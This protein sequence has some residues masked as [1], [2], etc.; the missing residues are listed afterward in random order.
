MRIHILQHVS[1][2]SPGLITDWAKEKK[3]SVNF[4]RF[5]EDER[6]PLRDNFDLLV[7]MGGPMNIYEKDKYPWLVREKA[8]LQTCFAAKKKI[9]GI[10]LG[11]QLL[12]DALGATVF[13]NKEKEIG[14]FPIHKNGS[15]KL[16]KLFSDSAISAF[17]WHGD[18]FDLPTGANLLFSSE[19]TKNQGFVFDNKVFGLQF[20]WEINRESLDSLILNSSGDLTPGKYVQT[21]EEM[22]KDVT[23]FKLVRNHLWT[24]LNFI[25]EL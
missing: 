7:I 14:W 5:Y 10:C 18:T 24:L 23:K 4:T 16:L 8:F 20:H 22:L 25:E 3:F 19:A 17:H 11:S 21:G 6:L 13:P 2:E 15:H 12:A 1:Y 9:L